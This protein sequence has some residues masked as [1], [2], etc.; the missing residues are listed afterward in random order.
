MVAWLSSRFMGMGNAR[1][2]TYVPDPGDLGRTWQRVGLKP[3]PRIGSGREHNFDTLRGALDGDRKSHFEGI[4][5]D[6]GLRRG[7]LKGPQSE[8]RD[9]RAIFA[10]GVELQ[11]TLPD[12][13]A[14]PAARP[15]KKQL[16]FG[17][18]AQGSKPPCRHRPVVRNLEAN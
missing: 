14:I 11:R 8:Y 10:R 18:W 4:G 7:A 5:K 9:F 15:G 2:D 16:A 17:V 13:R 12:N 1:E 3:A 6:F